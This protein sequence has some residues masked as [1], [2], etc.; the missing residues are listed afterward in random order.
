[1]IG[2]FLQG[3]RTVIPGLI[4][5]IFGVGYIVF[6]M[7]SPK[8]GFSNTAGQPFLLTTGGTSTRSATTTEFFGDVNPQVNNLYSVGAPDKSWRNIYASG[9]AALNTLIIGSGGCTGCTSNVDFSSISQSAG[10]SSNNAFDLG[11]ATRSWAGLYV[12]STARFGGASS[13]GGV[14]PTA[15]AT[16]GLGNFGLAWNGLYASGTSYFTDVVIAG[17]CTGCTGTTN[18]SSISQSPGPS[19]NNAFDLGYSTRSWANIYASGTAFLA[20]G[21]QSAPSLALGAVSNLGLFA[22]T[23][24]QLFITAG[25]L[26][27]GG[28]FGD[29]VTSTL[30]IGA[31]STRACINLTDADGSGETNVYALNGL[32]FSTTSSCSGGLASVNTM[33]P[34]V[35]KTFDLADAATTTI[36]WRNGDK[37]TLVLTGNRN[38]L[39][40]NPVDGATY[41]LIIRQD[42]TG[43]RT[44]A[45]TMFNGERFQ[46]SGNATPTLS[47]VANRADL[48]GFTYAS[49]PTGGT[50]YGYS[51]LGF[52]P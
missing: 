41:T 34:G 4:A 42:G 21:S 12:S 9:T 30:N 26:A 40:Q 25:G 43:S 6:G 49:G 5:L 32:L 23:T 35:R 3:K 15:N 44:A 38:L 17:S 7:A 29:T 39:L 37:Q 18:F 13:T 46:W 20:A 2:Q 45:F 14:Y 16:W 52:G 10:P 28:W 27:R 51:T 1:M 11:Y 19:S 48:L 8:F 24:N 33:A 36:D 50:Y 22:S 47:T 31:S